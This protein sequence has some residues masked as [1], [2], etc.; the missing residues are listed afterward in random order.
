MKVKMK[1]M[2]KE[3]NRFPAVLAAAVL[4]GCIAGYC[5][6]IPVEAAQAEVMEDGAALSPEETAAAV[7]FRGIQESFQEHGEIAG[8]SEQGNVL[9]E[10]VT[11]S[12]PRTELDQVNDIGIY[13]GKYYL[14]EEGV[15]KAFDLRDGSVIW[16]NSE[17]GGRA[18]GSAFDEDGTLYLCGYY[19]PDL[20]VVDKGGNT[21]KIISVID[22]NYMWPYKM[23][24]L[25]EWIAVTFAGT[26]SG[27]DEVI[28]IN[29]SDYSIS[30]SPDFGTADSGTENSPVSAN[31][32]ES[33]T[34]SSFLEEPQYGLVHNASNLM[35]GD[36]STAWVESA[37]GQGEGEAVTLK[38]N[39]TYKI[40][41]FIIHAGYQKNEDIYLKN[42]KPAKITVLFSDGTSQD[43]G[44]FNINGPQKITF[45]TAVN[46]SSMRIVIDSVYPGTKYQDTAVSEISL[47]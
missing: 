3:K 34:A 43:V 22:S 32:V 33:V 47:F 1:Q 17:F 31:A 23:E 16:S 27:G 29:R 13:D 12:Y 38:L 2:Q 8:I 4:A 35:D 21:E 45:R 5:P 37:D 42:S 18:Y 7:N 11:Q 46:T 40:S 20:F 26:P 36:L 41:G 39:G 19:G 24:I 30:R 25:G 14:A 9:W 44:L 6:G 15:V 28:Y 10:Y